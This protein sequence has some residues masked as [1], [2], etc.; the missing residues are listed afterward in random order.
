MGF[1]VYAPAMAELGVDSDPDTYMSLS[2]ADIDNIQVLN[3]AFD[4][5]GKARI[6]FRLLTDVRKS[7][8]L[9]LSATMGIATGRH[10]KVIADLQ[11]DAVKLLLDAWEDY[12]DATP[13][14]VR[15][16]RK[17]AELEED[18]D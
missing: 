1:F 16:E 17:M 11:A 10:K 9:W 13:D 7:G 14:V 2:E 4:D 12:E 5:E 15:F 8:R 6:D 18:D 3:V